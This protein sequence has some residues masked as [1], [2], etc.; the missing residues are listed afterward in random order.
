V[1]AHVPPPAARP[2]LRGG[3]AVDLGR[4]V[5][6]RSHRA[7]PA[8]TGY[9]RAVRVSQHVERR[10]DIA[11]TEAYDWRIERI[12]LPDGRF[13]VVCY[14]YDL[15]ERQ[16]L[17][18]ALRES[19][20]QLRATFEQ[21]AVGIAHVGL[22]GRWLRVNRRYCEIVGY[23]RDELLG[24]TFQEITHPDDVDADVSQLR[25]LLAGETDR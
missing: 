25:K 7:I 3:A 13:G 22:D 23:E 2:G 10:A 20:A 18:A 1:F 24:K 11:E 14:F 12:T 16:Q 15:S 17:E 6:E 9:R 4:A 8:H 5:R 19:E 21:A